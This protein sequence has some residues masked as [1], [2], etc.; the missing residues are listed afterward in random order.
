MFEN[1]CGYMFDTNSRFM[2][3]E[4][5]NISYNVGLDRMSN[6]FDRMDGRFRIPFDDIKGEECS[7]QA[8]G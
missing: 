7:P 1:E 8:W 4:L 6:F 2:M 5:Y 3:V